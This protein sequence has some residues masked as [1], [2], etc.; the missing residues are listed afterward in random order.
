MVSRNISLLNKLLKQEQNTWPTTVPPVE[1]TMFNTALMI[2][3]ALLSATLNIAR[4]Y[5]QLDTL[6]ELG[7]VGER[8]LGSFLHCGLSTRNVQTSRIVHCS[9][10]QSSHR[11]TTS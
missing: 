10:I 4:P 7:A 9:T 3:A 6:K 8:Q 1:S 2:G 5:L 11:H